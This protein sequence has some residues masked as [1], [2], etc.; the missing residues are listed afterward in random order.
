MESETTRFFLKL[1]EQLY[2]S[3]LEKALV[4]RINTLM[5]FPN[6]EASMVCEI[7]GYI[8]HLS[9]YIPVHTSLLSVLIFGSSPI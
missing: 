5:S 2:S 4:K 1:L 7:S 6:S 9:P 8:S 3:I